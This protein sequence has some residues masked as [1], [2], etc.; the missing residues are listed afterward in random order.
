MEFI[1]KEHPLFYQL[2]FSIDENDC[3]IKPLI[4]SLLE[5]SFQK[6]IYEE[7]RN[8]KLIDELTQYLKEEELTMI[9]YKD[10]HKTDKN[11]CSYSNKYL[12]RK[13]R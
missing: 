8:K 9:K 3:L 5:Y 7:E 6:L 11:K 1:T 4:I 13:Y 2:Y 10:L 12:K